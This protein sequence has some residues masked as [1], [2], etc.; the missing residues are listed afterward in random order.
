MAEPLTRD[1]GAFLRGPSFV[2]EEIEGLEKQLAQAAESGAGLTL[3]LSP[4]A[5]LCLHLVLIRGRHALRII[6]ELAVETWRLPGMAKLRDHR[7]A[8]I[9]AA[10]YESLRAGGLNGDGRVT[11]SRPDEWE[12][13]EARGACFVARE[14]GGPLDPQSA[15]RALAEFEGVPFNTMRTRLLRAK[16][17]LRACGED[18]FG[19]IPGGE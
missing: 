3:E 2:D 11:L 5:V 18:R 4:R 17:R 10:N 16:E 8:E 7:S 14:V 13:G 6:R 12:A 1:L 19:E 15:T 9:L